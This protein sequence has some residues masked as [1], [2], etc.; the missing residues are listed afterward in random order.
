M[1]QEA[2]PTSEDAPPRAQSLLP[3]FRS[4]P[5]HVIT[6]PAAPLAS[7]FHPGAT[8]SAVV[9]GDSSTVL[10][11]FPGGVDPFLGSG[12]TGLVSLEMH[13]RFIGVELNPDYVGIAERRLRNV[14]VC[15]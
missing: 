4:S 11:R 9:A 2:L 3:G 15:E 13:R 5:L 1:I 10:G 12:T 6:D 8:H 7:L 14:I